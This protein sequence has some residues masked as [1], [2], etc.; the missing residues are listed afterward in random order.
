MLCMAG[1][2]TQAVNVQAKTPRMASAHSAM[3]DS[4]SATAL[5]P[6]RFELANGLVVY[7]LEDH[8]APVVCEVLWVRVGSK[9][10]AAKATGFAH[11][12]EHLM[13]KGS[14]H[15]PDGR[16]DQ[17]LE[18]AGGLS[19]AATSQDYTVYHNVAASN[20]LEQ[21]LWMEADRFAGLTVALD[22]A[23]LDNQRDV[24][25]NERRQSY[26]NRPYGM[27]PLLIDASLWPQE[28]GYHWP[29][30]G[31]PAD[32]RAATLADVAS[33]FNS[34]YVPNNAT[35]VIAGDVSPE[36]AKQLVHKYF[37]WMPRGRDP[38]RPRYPQPAPI[39]KPLR[40]ESTDSVQVPRVHIAWRGPA[41]YSPDEP[42]FS[43]AATILGDGKSS[44]LYR[45]LVYAERV[46]QDVRVESDGGELAG[47]LRI[48]VTAKP[49]VGARRLESEVLQEVDKLARVT[50]ERREL[51]RAANWRE[52]T[53][54]HELEPLIERARQIAEYDVL[55]HDAGYFSKDLARYRGVTVENIT[56]V[57]KKYL[58][59]A[60]RLTLVIKPGD[61]TIG[62]K[63][64]SHHRGQGRK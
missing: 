58:A 15:I 29:T 30:I 26:E 35:M 51:E 60:M 38:K 64:T 12:F 53:F 42:A 34:F 28:F 62:R 22:Q 37:A 56:A 18:A 5:M 55:A 13:F 36:Q 41:A 19:N 32:L 54:L 16:M 47:S 44:R 8:H 11:L 33:F 21:I 23:K 46:A 9:D 25:L 63:I 4:H 49:G 14:A 17:L 39:A 45:R 10:E 2:L 48:I 1:L 31:Y 59:P 27:A 43:L 50:P 61:K 20:F 52:A 24:V 7:V 40:M 6:T 57:A 3:A